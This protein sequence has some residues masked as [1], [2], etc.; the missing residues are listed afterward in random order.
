MSTAAAKLIC[1]DTHAHVFRR[2]LPLMPGFRHAPEHDALLP[3]LLDIFNGHGIT[4]GVLTAP[5]FYGTDNSFLLAALAAAPDRLRGTV[6]VDST[7]PRDRLEALS[8]QGVIG[9]RLNMLRRPDLPD[10]RSAAWRRVLEDAAALDWHLEIY[11]EGPRLPGLLAPALETGIKVVIDHFG[12][13]DPALRLDCPGFRIVLDAVGTGRI[14]VKLSA[15]YR[16]GGVDPKPY[17]AALLHAGGPERLVWASDWPWTQNSA[18]HTYAKVLGWLD[19]WVPDPAQR[20]IILDDTPRAVFGF[21]GG[22]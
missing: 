13:P 12:S 21:A 18:G 6:I 7:I 8:A 2:D 19:R 15:P 14:W 9:I 5:S 3:E 1:I 20:R 4:H 10:L 17:A 16:L 22:F 11:V